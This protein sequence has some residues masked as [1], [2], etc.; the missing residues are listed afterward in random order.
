MTSYLFNPEA[1][2]L[3][4]DVYVYGSM[5]SVRDVEEH[6]HS[7]LAHLLSECEA[8]RNFE[9]AVG[10]F[11]YFPL[12]L[13][14]GAIKEMFLGSIDCKLDWE[15]GHLYEKNVQRNL[16]PSLRQNHQTSS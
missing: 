15:Y 8:V 14:R 11:L 7:A 10:V 4:V 6:L 16:Y 12:S 13:E 2:A 5:T 9:G 1:A 3:N